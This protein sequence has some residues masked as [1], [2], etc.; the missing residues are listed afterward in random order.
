MKLFVIDEET[1]Q[2]LINVPW[3]KLVPE[4]R[5][6]FFQRTTKAKDGYERDAEGRKRLAY[7]YFMLDFS[8]PLRDYSDEDKEKNALDYTGLTPT[9]VQSESMISAIRRYQELQYKQSRKLKSYR[10]MQKG[11]DAMDD[12]F[13]NVDFEETDKMGKPKYTPNSYADSIAKINKAYD[14]LD[15]MSLTIENELAA[16][17]GIRGKSTLGDKEGKQQLKKD[18]SE[19][20]NEDTM[21]DD[22]ARKWIDLT[23]TL[24]VINPNDEEDDV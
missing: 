5:A 2:V 6:L 3:I 19:A 13:E 14:E 24:N 10:S 23:D 16:S 7:I 12:Y 4:F 9:D 8:S 1:N 18:N 21:P 17:T 11:L 22:S 15:K 20:W